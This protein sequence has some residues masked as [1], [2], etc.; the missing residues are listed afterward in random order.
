MKDMARVLGA[1]RKDKVRALESKEEPWIYQGECMIQPGVDFGK[2]GRKEEQ[3]WV[4]DR[5]RCHRRSWSVG[6]VER[7]AGGRLLVSELSPQ[8]WGSPW[9]KTDLKEGQQCW[10][11][12]GEGKPDPFRLPTAVVLDGSQDD[13][14]SL[15]SLL[16]RCLSTLT[17]GL[18]IPPAKSCTVRTPLRCGREL[19]SYLTDHG[20]DGPSEMKAAV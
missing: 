6:G 7:G 2:E 11:V 10:T 1:I 12:K 18:S 13:E 4:W 3:G 9:G 8:L 15:S 5:V 16:F 17:A 20:S 14:G 19:V